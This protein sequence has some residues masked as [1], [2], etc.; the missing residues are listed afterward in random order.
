MATPTLAG[1]CGCKGTAATLHGGAL[2]TAW[3]ITTTTTEN[4]PST[5]ITLLEE[6]GERRCPQLVWV[7]ELVSFRHGGYWRW[8][9]RWPA[10]SFLIFRAKVIH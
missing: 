2:K 8:R 3:P 6:S 10:G 7:E 9:R 1:R 5:A 4:R